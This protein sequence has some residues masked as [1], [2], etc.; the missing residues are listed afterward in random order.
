[1]GECDKIKVAVCTPVRF[2][3]GWSRLLCMERVADLHVHTTYSDSIYS[4]EQV[5][6]IA[7]ERGL[8]AIGICDHDSVSGIE[9]A[10]ELESRY[11][12]EVVPGIELS[13]EYRNMEVHILGYFMDWNDLQFQALLKTIQEV[14]K[15]RAE[16]MVTKLRQ[17]GFNLEF[18]EVLAE[19]DKGAVGR[20]HIARLMVKKGYVATMDEAFEKYL[21]Y[22]G[23]AY[24]PKYNMLPEEAVRLVRKL[25]GI[26]VLAHPKFSPLSEE[27]IEYLIS[28][29]LRGIEAY[30]ARHTPE[31]AQQ[32]VA[33]AE[34]Y[35][36]LITGGSDS[37]GEEDP[38]GCVRLPYEHVRRLKE[39]RKRMVFE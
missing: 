4:P 24:V 19:S 28:Q 29:G 8:A 37:H 36:L 30:H 10:L 39:E 21:K 14:R 12:V 26:P 2:L 22:G 38:I 6:R 23:P 33:L 27:E 18:E 16:L 31:E 35:G 34:K 25:R 5:L 20:P 32:Y 13:T 17:L 11:G 1:M 7:K 9:E 3:G 15:W